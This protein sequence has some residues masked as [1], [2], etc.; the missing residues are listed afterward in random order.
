MVNQLNLTHGNGFF[1]IL[2]MET[3]L[4]HVFS[5]DTIGFTVQKWRF[6]AT[7]GDFTGDLPLMDLTKGT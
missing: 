4:F 3:D 2:P 1:P 6:F 7:N 5:V